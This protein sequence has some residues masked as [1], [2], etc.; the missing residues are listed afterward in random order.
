M[1]RCVLQAGQSSYKGLLAYLGIPSAVFSIKKIR[2]TKES[3]FRKNRK[4]VNTQV[5]NLYILRYRGSLLWKKI[6]YN[7]F[8]GKLKKPCRRCHCC[9]FS[10]C[11]RLLHTSL[12]MVPAKNP[13]QS[14][15]TNLCPWGYPCIA[16]QRALTEAYKWI[17]V[18]FGFFFSY[19]KEWRK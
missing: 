18:W 11:A 12:C 16:F 2:E 8:I 10:G 17:W 19:K 14:H 4:K 5:F 13:A 7:F 3:V 6:N 9:R 1:A 15:P